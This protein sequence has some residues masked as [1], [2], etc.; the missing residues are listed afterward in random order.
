MEA[1]ACAGL[2]PRAIV[3]ISGSVKA[4]IALSTYRDH[5]FRFWPF[6]WA[7]CSQTRASV[8]QHYL[9]KGCDADALHLRR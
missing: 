3:L 7:S 1:L 4:S 9:S 5:G 2:L 8:T 6:R